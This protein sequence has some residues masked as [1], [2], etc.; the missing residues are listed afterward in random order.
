MPSLFS[1]QLLICA[2]LSHMTVSFTLSS[3]FEQHGKQCNSKKI[4]HNIHTTR[5]ENNIECNPL[6]RK[7]SISPLVL[8]TSANTE[9]DEPLSRTSQINKNIPE[10]PKNE[11]SENEEVILIPETNPN[12]NPNAKSLSGVQYKYVSSGIDT[13]Y[14]PLELSSRNAKSRTDGY[15]KYVERGEKPP[16]HFTYGE[17]DL[18]FFGELLD[19]AWGHFSDGI[20]GD[21]G[22]NSPKVWEDRVFCDIGS[23]TGRLVIAAAA[24]HPGWKMCRGIEILEGIHNTALDAASKCMVSSKQLQ[25]PSSVSAS[26]T[27]SNEYVQSEAD[28]FDDDLSYILRIPSQTDNKNNTAEKSNDVQPIFIRLA[29]ISFTCGSF[30]DPYEY[31]GDIDCAFVFSSCMKPDLV[32]ELSLAI[33]RQC[34]PGTIIITTEFPLFLRGTV[35]AVEGDDM[36][37]SGPFEIQLLERIDGWCWLMGGESTAYIHRV[38]SSLWK[39]YAG[40]R[41]IPLEEEAYQLVQM[42]EKGELTNTKMFLRKVYNNIVF[43]GLPPEWLPEINED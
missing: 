24:L 27:K 26:V 34:K 36:I 43:N 12:A 32:Q 11:S 20:N 16:Q 19:A 31:L 38:K 10:L 22:K 1:L 23:G 30:T 14:P 25:Q 41:E 28:F 5:Q 40:P 6:P 35:E 21:N 8:F 39:D 17:F 42:I 4:P 9:S 7:N 13:L 29:P 37:P 33:G 18:D 15:W 3:R 2:Y